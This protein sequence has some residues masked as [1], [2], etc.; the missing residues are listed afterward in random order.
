M[1]PTLAFY[2]A[3]NRFADCGFVNNLVKRL[4]LVAPVPEFL[5]KPRRLK[6]LNE[7][8]PLML[9]GM[10][11]GRL[12]WGGAY[13]SFREREKRAKKIGVD[14]SRAIIGDRYSLNDFWIAETTEKWSPWFLG[15][16]WD[17]TFFVF[18]KKRAILSILVGTDTD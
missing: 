2:L 1:H 4:S 10:L 5:Q 9:D 11:A 6:E 7:V 8:D 12:V 15:I 3:R 16:A 14:A 18:D 17:S 13:A